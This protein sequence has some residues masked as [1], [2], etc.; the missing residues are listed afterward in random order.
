MAV[1]AFYGNIFAHVGE[2]LLRDRQAKT[3]SF[4]SACTV[5]LKEPLENVVYVV[6]VYTLSRIGYG[7]VYLSDLFV[8]ITRYRYAS[9]FRCV[10][11][12]VIKEYDENL[13]NTVR[14]TYN[15]RKLIRSAVYTEEYSG[16]LHYR[17]KSCKDTVKQLVQIER[18]HLES[19]R[20]GLKLRQFKHVV[21]KT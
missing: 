7:D 15:C 17:R 13:V 5:S 20:S 8:V 9:A 11:L 16:I 14:V 21:D 19:D 18:I 2:E 10:L 12:G 3:G 1:F 4:L 6:L